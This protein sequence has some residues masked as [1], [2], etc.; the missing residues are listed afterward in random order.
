MLAL[1][2]GIDPAELLNMS[3][4][5]FKGGKSPG[6]NSSCVAESK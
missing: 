3:K 6:C 1:E 4:K 2:K 5:H